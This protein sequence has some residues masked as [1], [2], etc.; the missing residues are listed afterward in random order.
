[1][2]IQHLYIQWQLLLFHDMEMSVLV[3]C[4]LAEKDLLFSP[5]YNV[6]IL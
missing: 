4:S 3:F 1:M 6:A 5:K 2:Y